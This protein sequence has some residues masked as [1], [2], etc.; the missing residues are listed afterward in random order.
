MS[1][2]RQLS[3][4]VGDRSEYS[5]RK[6]VLK[7]LETP[8]L[9]NDIVAGLSNSDPAMVGDCAEVLT[10]VAETQPDLVLPFAKTISMLI[11][12]KYTRARWEATHA[13]ANIAPYA[14][15]LLGTLLP[16]LG[17]RIVS[18]PSVIVR[19]Y[20]VDAIAN[21]A[22]SGRKAAEQAYPFLKQALTT[23]DGKQA[24]HA[25]AGLVNVAQHVP[26][27]REELAAISED[28]IEDGR[29]VVRKAAKGLAKATGRDKRKG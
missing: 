4:Q 21:Y 25:L 17:Q 8:T 11:N 23:F 9:L 28:Y 18:D 20:A 2:L 22:S 15:R 14:P 16:Q 1:I 12:H 6:V 5:N 3:S 13:L 10:Q 19:D 27:L 7:C 24:G 26:A 29:G